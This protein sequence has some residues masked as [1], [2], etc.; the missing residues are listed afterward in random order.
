GSL[1]RDTAYVLG[2]RLALL[3][4]AGSHTHFCR[5]VD[6]FNL[7]TYD[8]GR[9]EES[10]RLADIIFPPYA[11]GSEF[12]SQR[13]TPKWLRL[14]NFDP[15]PA[16]G[17]WTLGRKAAVDFRVSNRPPSDLRLDLYFA[18]VNL[19]KAHQRQRANLS[20]NGR[21]VGTIV[22]QFPA[23]SGRRT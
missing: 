17:R 5:R 9:A 8:P 3:A 22:F 21:E 12:L 7:C 19:S 23:N 6:G 18:N 1:Q 13:S 4:S 11:F 16:W 14:E 20:L 2:D 15:G 10:S